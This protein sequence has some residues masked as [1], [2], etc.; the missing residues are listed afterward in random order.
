M[1]AAHVT[2]IGMALLLTTFL[3]AVARAQPAVIDTDFARGD[4]KALGPTRP[5]EVPPP[6]ESP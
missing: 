2:Q 5:S 3:P 6:L 4:F 1:A